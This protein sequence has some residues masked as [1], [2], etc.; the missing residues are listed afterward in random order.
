MSSSSSQLTNQRLHTYDEINV[1]HVYSML[2]HLIIFL[3]ESRWQSADRSAV[4]LD[5]MNVFYNY[6]YSR[7]SHLLIFLDE[8]RRQSAD[9]SA[10]ELDEMNVPLVYSM[11]IR[12]FIFLDELR[13]QSADQS[14]VALDEM[15]VS[16][17]YSRLT[18]PLIFI[19]GHPRYI[20]TFNILLVYC[21][22]LHGCQIYE[23]FTV[24]CTFL[25]NRCS[26]AGKTIRVLCT[27]Q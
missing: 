1:S 12:L 19:G 13:R 3:D 24:L 11:F 7:L 9:Q 2:S 17:V 10:V 6:M 16:H 8:L 15:N 27:V 14:A 23:H 22:V 5:E 4:A 21:S 18:H 26:V 25:T 20:F